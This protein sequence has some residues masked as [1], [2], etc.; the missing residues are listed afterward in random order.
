M[1]E[2]EKDKCLYDYYYPLAALLNCV[3]KKKNNELYEAHD[4]DT[5]NSHGELFGTFLAVD[6]LQKTV[7]QKIFCTEVID[8]I[9]KMLK[10]HCMLELPKTKTTSFVG[11]LIADK[12][13][14]LPPELEKMIESMS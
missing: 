12:L 8:L 11:L 6:I 3:L 10:S 9:E 5:C 7:K 4:I 1:T 14:K 2:I 13:W